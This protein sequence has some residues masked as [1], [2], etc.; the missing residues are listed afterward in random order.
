MQTVSIARYELPYPPST[1][2]LFENAKK[3]RVKTD[4]YQAWR[5][6]AGKLIQMQGRKRVLGQVALSVDLVKPDRRKRD[7]SN[8]LKAVED[9]LV[10]MQVIDD[11]S[12]VQALSV[13]W[14]E[15]GVPC[16][17]TVTGL[18]GG[19]PMESPLQ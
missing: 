7:L 5:T 1:N 8:T 17:V 11:D 18:S 16:V 12:L 3:G 6:T 9:L 10:E 2:N 4:H 19:S 14:V 15:S 13:Q